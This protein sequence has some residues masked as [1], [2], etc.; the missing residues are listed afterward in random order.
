MSDEI[1]E[2]PEEKSNRTLWIILAIVAVI[3]LCCC[4]LAITLG[5]VGAATGWFEDMYYYFIPALH[6]I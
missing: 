4:C 3:I 6:M 2:A 1:Y 5:I